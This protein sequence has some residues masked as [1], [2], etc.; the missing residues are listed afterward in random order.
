M[1]YACIYAWLSGHLN[2]QLLM[3]RI[4]VVAHVLSAAEIREPGS[5][6]GNSCQLP[7]R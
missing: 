5:M 4:H 1:R 2:I 7:V 3:L 6:Y